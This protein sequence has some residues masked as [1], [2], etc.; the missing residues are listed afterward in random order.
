MATKIKRK[1][2]KKKKRLSVQGSHHVW[3]G[4]SQP[5]STLASEEIVFKI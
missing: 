5:I 2:E 4:K 3:F 1:K